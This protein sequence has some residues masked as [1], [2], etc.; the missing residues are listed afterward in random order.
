MLLMVVPALVGS[1]GRARRPVPLEPAVLVGGCL[2]ILGMIGPSFWL[3]VRKSKRQ[4]QLPP[5]PARRPR[6]PGDLPRGGAEP[7]GGVRS[8]SAPSCR[9]AH[10]LLALELNIV[11]AR[12]SSSAGSPGESLQQMGLRTDLEEIRSLASVITQAERFGASLV[13][14]LRVHAET[15]GSSGSSMPRRWPRRRRSRSSS[16]RLLFIFPA[17]FVVILGPAAFQIAEVMMNLGK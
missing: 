2:G 8:G 16:R 13:K 7:A 4:I 15:S 12:E 17:I 3:D 5:G 14:S 1:G 9:T 6:R 11:A 10:P